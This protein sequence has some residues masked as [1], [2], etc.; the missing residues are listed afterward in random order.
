V[1]G[2]NTTT[3]ARDFE[4]R[5]SR[6]MLPGSGATVGFKL[7]PFGRNAVRSNSTVR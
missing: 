7:D 4:N 6:V 3:Q 2:S 1:V 5:L